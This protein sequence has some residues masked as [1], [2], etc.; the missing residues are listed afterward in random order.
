MLMCRMTGWNPR[1]RR[2][3]RWKATLRPVIW[4][5][6]MMS[7]SR[8]LLVPV[9]PRAGGHTAAPAQQTATSCRHRPAARGRSAW[10]NNINVGGAACQGLWGGDQGHAGARGLSRSVAAL[11]RSKGIARSGPGA[12]RVR[13]LSVVGGRASCCGVSH[14]PSCRR[15]RSSRTRRRGSSRAR[16]LMRA[17]WCGA[18]RSPP[19]RGPRALAAQGDNPRRELIAGLTRSRLAESAM[20]AL[21]SGARWPL[22]R[23]SSGS[24]TPAPRC[25]VPLPRQWGSSATH[26]RWRG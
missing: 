8:R 6:R 5:G 18:G 1:S 12:S 9:F 26:G 19:G 13:R 14:R 11:I 16:W 7:M 24:V 3:V 4:R 25:E 2:E 21:G 22:L 17:R 23:S 20:E 10:R 15:P